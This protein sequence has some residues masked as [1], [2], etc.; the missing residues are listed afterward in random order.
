[1]KKMLILLFMV[2]ATIATYAQL[3]A[4]LP[5]GEKYTYGG[6][7]LGTDGNTY[8]KWYNSQGQ[9]YHVCKACPPAQT[10]PAPGPAPEPRVITTRD[11]DAEFE[12]FYQGIKIGR[13]AKDDYQ[14]GIA[15]GISLSGQQSSSQ[16]YYTTNQGQ[17]GCNHS[18]N[19]GGS[20]G[21]SGRGSGR[22]LDIYNAIMSTVSAG[23]STANLV[24]SVKKKQR[25]FLPWAPI[26]GGQGGDG[27]PIF[28]TN[29]I[30]TT[31]PGGPLTDYITTNGYGADGNGIF[32]TTQQSQGVYSAPG[33]ARW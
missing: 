26:P 3:P 31:N 27:G 11:P 8:E 24:V 9:E 33:R 29:P 13:L 21:N 25:P 22:G 32:R 10:S 16:Q 2:V 19:C 28:G 5:A 4:G 12:K 15:D 18:G 17:S 14:E 23:A 20:C 6:S 7:F 30:T 1:M